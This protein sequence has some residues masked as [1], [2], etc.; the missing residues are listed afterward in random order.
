MAYINRKIIPILK[1]TLKRNK[2]ILLLGPRQTGKTT[3]ILQQLQPDICYS[4]V[5]QRTRIRFEKD[6]TLLEK[7]LE[8]KIQ[9]LNKKPV[10]FIDEIQKIPQLM[11]SVQYIIDKGLAVFILSGSSARKLKHGPN[12]NLLPGRVVKFILDPLLFSELPEN[13][14]ILNDIL[15]YG[16]LPGIINEQEL[17]NKE[18]D[19]YSYVS[20]YLT[21]EIR[22]EAVVRKIG[23][24]ARFLEIA[25]SESG[26][27]VNNTKLSQ[28]VGVASSTISEYFQILEDCL[29]VHRVDPITS[30]LSKRR[31]IKSPKYLFFDLGVRRA[32]AEEGPKLS[33][34]ILGNLF[35]Q[36]IGLELIH[37]ARYIY[38]NVKIKY[39]RD[40]SNVEVD[41][42]IDNSKNYIPIEV[43]FTANPGLKEA[44]HLIK[45][46][47]EYQQAQHGF[48][49]CQAE[50][51]YK[52]AN[53]ITALPWKNVLD[54]LSDL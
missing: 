3:L 27:I 15:L 14:K 22:A 47:E 50:E 16:T 29:I 11:D 53:N 10:I 39:W 40:T 54:I 12:I 48:I 7:E 34:K 26:S 37:N 5:E 36:Y 31:L 6:P 45:F 13:K 18:Q 24:F 19:L 8:L 17:D 23:D 9:S 25:A 2:S 4:L 43:K 20:T 1:N 28:E 44:K 30:S 38:P 52:I 32:A 21:E 49:I 42:V 46:L 35:E 51:P 41:F 33:Q